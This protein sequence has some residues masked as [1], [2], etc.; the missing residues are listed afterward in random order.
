MARGSPLL[1]GTLGEAEFETDCCFPPEME[2]IV[3][4]QLFASC[5]S[6]TLNS[7]F[8][9]SILDFSWHLSQSCLFY[10][11]FRIPKKKA[12]LGSLKVGSFSRREIV[13][14]ESKSQIERAS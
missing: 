5:M 8:R 6:Y 2:G 13:V 12:D 3:A 14:T 10:E 9:L 4:F 1:C 11:T 7:H